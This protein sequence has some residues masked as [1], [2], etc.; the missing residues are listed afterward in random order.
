MG[1]PIDSESKTCPIFGLDGRQSQALTCCASPDV[2]AHT[3]G[4]RVPE[5]DG[6]RGVLVGALQGRTGGCHVP[7]VRA[8]LLDA[9]QFWPRGSCGYP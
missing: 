9:R 6:L 3:G 5:P 1:V 7:G 2:F 8:L 4:A